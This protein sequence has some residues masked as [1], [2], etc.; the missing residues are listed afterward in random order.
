[1]SRYKLI[2]PL[3]YIL[4]NLILNSTL[5]IKDPCLSQS[6][7]NEIL[8]LILDRARWRKCRQA[9]GPPPMQSLAI[10]KLGLDLFVP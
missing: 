3:S 2:N 6:F 9:Q 5:T 4:I 8:K 1:M 7:Q 10:L